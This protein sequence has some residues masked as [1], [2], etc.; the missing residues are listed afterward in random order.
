MAKKCESQW[1][2]NKNMRVLIGQCEG[3]N[4]NQFDVVQELLKACRSCADTRDF[5]G[6]TA[7]ARAFDNKDRTAAQLLVEYTSLSSIYI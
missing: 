1:E 3:L 7:F 4:Q 6:N 2:L 5:D